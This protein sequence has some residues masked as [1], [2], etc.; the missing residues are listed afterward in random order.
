MVPLSFQDFEEKRIF[1][2]K[3]INSNRRKS[4]M[5]DDVFK[6]LEEKGI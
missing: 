1:S 2:R 6:S 5:L 3:E 4:I